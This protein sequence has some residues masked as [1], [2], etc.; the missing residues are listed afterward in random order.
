MLGKVRLSFYR[1]WLG[2]DRVEQITL[3]G[4]SS[5]SIYMTLKMEG[6]WLKCHQMS[7]GGGRLEKLSLD[8]FLLLG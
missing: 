8:I 5:K 4:H 3:G 1:H 6:C 2:C 7:H